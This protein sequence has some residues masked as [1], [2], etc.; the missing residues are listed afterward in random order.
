MLYLG[1]VRNDDPTS[2]TST[3][4]DM[5][6]F[7]ALGILF[8]SI[9]AS[10]L[11]RRVGRFSIKKYGV[12][13][14]GSCTCTPTAQAPQPD[15][16]EISLSYY[17]ED[18]IS[19]GKTQT[20]FKNATDSVWKLIRSYDSDPTHVSYKISICHSMH[21]DPAHTKKKFLT[22]CRWIGIQQK[23]WSIVESRSDLTCGHQ[24]AFALVILVQTLQRF[25][26][27]TN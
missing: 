12:S 17:P 9:Q 8:L 27:I 21:R 15:M 24:I 4:L 14:A 19:D 26:T 16:L 22:P 11:V 6:V 20:K 3:D 23:A 5:A 10:R 18:G 1:P 7:V 13:S 25:Q 2:G